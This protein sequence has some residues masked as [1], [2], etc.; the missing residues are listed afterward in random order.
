L[1]KPVSREMA[2]LCEEIGPEDGIDPRILFASRARK[3]FDRKAY[4]LCKQAA[5]AIDMALCDLPESS[6][7]R[8][9]S[10]LRVEPAPDSSRLLVL[11]GPNLQGP[12]P[13]EEA[14]INA[15]DSEKGH[16]RD[17]IAGAIN[18]KKAPALIL[19]FL[20]IGEVRQ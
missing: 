14:V 11:F 3:S 16:L 17:E 18:R 8:D 1:K 6:V 4:Q 12:I 9:V 20:P 15:L 19:R 13:G 10:V 2:S 5:Q 7:L